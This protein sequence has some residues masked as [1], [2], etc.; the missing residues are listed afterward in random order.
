MEDRP[1]T[2]SNQ[3]ALVLTLVFIAAETL[4]C[5]FRLLRIPSDAKNAFLF[6][7]SKE[8]LLMLAAFGFL[9]LL[10]LFLIIRRKTLYER[11]LSKCGSQHRERESQD[12]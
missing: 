5:E 4:F 6:G 1:E 7:L 10:S 12:D 8:R 2:H 9:F 11:F 3:R